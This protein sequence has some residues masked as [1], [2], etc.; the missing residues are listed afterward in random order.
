[1]NTRFE[2]LMIIFIVLQCISIALTVVS[3]V[4]KVR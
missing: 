2:K 3:I 4:L 1:M